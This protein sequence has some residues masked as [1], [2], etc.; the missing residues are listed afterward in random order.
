MRHRKGEKK[1]KKRRLFKFA[2]HAYHT[3]FLTHTYTKGEN[4]ENFHKNFFILKSY[5]KNFLLTFS[6]FSPFTPI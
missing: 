6:P 4:E 3:V 5:F 2:S 1:E